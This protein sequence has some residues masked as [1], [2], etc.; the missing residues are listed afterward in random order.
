M[1]RQIK[2]G[3]A[4]LLTSLAVCGIAYLCK[5]RLAEQ[6][7]SSNQPEK[8]ISPIGLSYSDENRREY[9]G[10]PVYESDRIIQKVYVDRKPFGSLD[11]IVIKWAYINGQSGV[12]P[13]RRPL[14]E[15]NATFSVLEEYAKR[16]HPNI[17]D[18][19]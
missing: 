15:E 8:I 16:E 7:Q 13:E 3:I 5:P 2:T 11:G 10:V 18:A 14:Y 17:Q 4:I 12:Q 9:T 19:E 1:E 6:S